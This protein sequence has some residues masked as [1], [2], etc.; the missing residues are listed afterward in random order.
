MMKTVFISGANG[1]IAQH[2]I[3][4]L[5][6]DNKYRV[7]GSVRSEDK[8]DRIGQQFKSPNL[9]LEVVPDISKL[10]AFDNLFQKHGKDIKV[11]LHTSS[12]VS[13]STDDYE[14][15]VLLPA[16]NGTRS[17]LEAIKKYCPQT[18]EKVVITSSYAAVA[19]SKQEYQ[20]GT[21]ITEDTWNPVTWEEA[22]SGAEAYSGSK[23]F[24]EK[25]AWDFWNANRDQ[26]KFE[27]T[28]INPVFVFGPQAFDQN[29][30]KKL[31][32]SCEIINRYLN[33]T[34]ETEVDQKK[35]GSFIDVR[36]LARA[37]LAAFENAEL[38]GQRLIVAAARFSFQDIVDVLNE[39]FPQLKGKIAIGKPGAGKR[40]LKEISV[41]D[42]SK[43]KK[44]LGIDFMPFS[45]SI[46]DTVDQILKARGQ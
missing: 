40:R 6:K 33:T 21:V 37:H 8:A 1:Y 32:A 18:V 5:L 2:I 44:L 15:D 11:V 4:Q 13:Y 29:V 3:K 25:A 43:T 28:V 26:V 41:L 36:D 30:G 24:A 17:V 7:I 20:R 38:A 23:T 31:N 22:I 19:G 46:D 39:D 45:K 12:P 27:M 14:K 10:N 9:T 42:N 35:A 34:P 16:I